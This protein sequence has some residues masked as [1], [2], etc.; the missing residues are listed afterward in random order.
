MDCPLM[1]RWIFFVFGSLLIMKASAQRVYTDNSVLSTGNWYRIAVS[2][3][4]VY[5]VDAAFLN[6]LGIQGTISY[7]SHTPVR[8]WR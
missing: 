8:E 6:N 1:N 5:K 2:A 7:C 3:P 4:G